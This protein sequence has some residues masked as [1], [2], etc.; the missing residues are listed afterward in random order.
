MELRAQERKKKE[1]K[2][3]VIHHS[4]IVLIKN[5]INIISHSFV[6]GRGEDCTIF[7]SGGW[8]V[9]GEVGSSFHFID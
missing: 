8:R 4:T 2:K 9:C 6:T 3:K 7:V 1:K 5:K